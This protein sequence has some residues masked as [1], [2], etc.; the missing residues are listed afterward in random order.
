MLNM[1]VWIFGSYLHLLFVIKY[2]KYFKFG[3]LKFREK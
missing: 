1:N 3:G 2:I